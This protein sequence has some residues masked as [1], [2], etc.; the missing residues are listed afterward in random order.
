MPTRNFV[1]IHGRI[2][3]VKFGINVARRVI[4]HGATTTTSQLSRRINNELARRRQ[5]TTIDDIMRG[6]CSKAL[7]MSLFVERQ[8]FDV[9]RSSYNSL[10]LGNHRTS[11]K[12]LVG[13]ETPA[14]IFNG[15]D[16]QRNSIANSA[17]TTTNLV[18][19]VFAS[20]RVGLVYGGG[21]GGGGNFVRSQLN[22]AA[23][24]R[25]GDYGA[26]GGDYGAGA[27]KE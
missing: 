3:K 21:D 19:I 12:I 25:H 17:Q 4:S 5:V 8:E 26:G 9:K 7:Q 1:R 10:V 16:A 22:A 2:D 13:K 6:N 15:R 27:T 11:A 20:D 23:A 24:S 14:G 18:V